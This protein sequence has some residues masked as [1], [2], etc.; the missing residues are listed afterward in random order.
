MP[1]PVTSNFNLPTFIV[2]AV[3]AATG[4][5]SAGWN[6]VPYISSGA[7]IHVAIGLVYDVS[8]NP[9]F[10][11]NAYNKRRGPVGIADWGIRTH[12]EAS[13]RKYPTMWWTTAVP[14]SSGIM[15]IQGQHSARWLVEARDVTAFEINERCE[16]RVWGVVKLGNGKEG[17]SRSLKLQA[18]ALHRVPGVAEA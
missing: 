14:G 2:A 9:H 16:V 3:G 18:G 12:D 5:F 17:K 1:A 4:L 6:V 15:T 13:G 8:A 10:E 7:K 11:V